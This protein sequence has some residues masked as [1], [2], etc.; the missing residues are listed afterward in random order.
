[1]DCK[2]KI[3]HYYLE[4]VESSSTTFDILN[5]W[6]VS[7]TK[8]QIPS[9]IARD[10]LAIPVTIVASKLA[11]NAGGCVL[12]PVWEFYGFKNNKGTCRHT[13]NWLRSSPITC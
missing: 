12:D 7:L 9:K 13:Q 4:D 2:S 1:M 3:D 10:V 8:F 5:W 11:F 6:K